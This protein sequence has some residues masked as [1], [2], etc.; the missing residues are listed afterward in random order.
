ML[1]TPLQLQKDIS[2]LL[3]QLYNQLEQ[4]AYNSEMFIFNQ[5][6]TLDI[7]SQLGKSY[8]SRV[9]SLDNWISLFSQMLLGPKSI[10]K[11]GLKL[12]LRV[13]QDLNISIKTKHKNKK[14]R[15]W[16]SELD[17]SGVGEREFC[18]IIA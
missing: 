3:P 10:E 17:N 13:V 7:I 9:F 6:S 1:R 14:K 12:P 8:L 2:L 5:E 4:W 18:S 11:Y 15:K 16:E